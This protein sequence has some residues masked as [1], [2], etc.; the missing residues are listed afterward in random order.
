[1]QYV[2]FSTSKTYLRECFLRITVSVKK[3]IFENRIRNSFLEII[4]FDQTREI[5]LY[6]RL[7]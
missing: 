4:P 1:M 2:I 5:I 3:Y 6:A 7:R